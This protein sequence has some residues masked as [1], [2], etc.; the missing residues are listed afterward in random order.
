MMVNLQIC[1]KAVGIFE[2]RGLMSNHATCC[3]ERK[4]NLLN[5]GRFFVIVIIII[6]I[7]WI[8]TLKLAF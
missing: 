3:L 1:S 6:I 4:G 2:K 7:I 8:P 5:Q